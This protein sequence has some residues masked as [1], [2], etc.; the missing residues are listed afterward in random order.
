MKKIQFRNKIF[1]AI[2]ALL[3]LTSKGQTMPPTFGMKWIGYLIDKCRESQITIDTTIPPKRKCV[4]WAD[5]CRHKQ[6]PVYPFV[7]HDSLIRKQLLK[8]RKRY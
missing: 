2:I 5:S 3:P 6:K 4:Q 8:N 1:V 7:N